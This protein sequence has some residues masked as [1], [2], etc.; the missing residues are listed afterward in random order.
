MLSQICQT[1]KDEYCM[2]ARVNGLQKVDLKEV[3]RVSVVTRGWE[4][5]EG[6]WEEML[7]N[8]FDSQIRVRSFD[9]LLYNKRS[10]DKGNELCI[11][12]EDQKKEL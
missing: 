11:C 5:K 7:S 10:I 9:I 3:E 4:E 12:N 2:T 8:R 6:D 1:Q